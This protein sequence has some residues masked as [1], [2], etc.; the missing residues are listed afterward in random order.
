[1]SHDMETLKLGFHNPLVEPILNN[2]I[3]YHKKL[4]RSSQHHLDDQAFHRL[5]QFHFF[6]MIK[7]SDKKKVAQG[8]K[9]FIWLKQ[10]QLWF[11]ISGKSHSRNLRQLIMPHP[12]S[13]AVRNQ[14]IHAFCLHFGSCPVIDS[15]FLHSTQVMVLP[16]MWRVLLYQLTIKAAL[17]SH[18]Y[19]P[20]LS[21]QFFIHALS[22]V[23][24][25]C[26]ELTLNYLRA[27]ELAQQF[28]STDYFCRAL[29]FSS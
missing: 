15:L 24:L 29:R 2:I 23:I 25:S 22:E 1:M 4:I 3:I 14:Y 17:H 12:Q 7:Y 6:T 11:I 20:T 18:V 9:R 16:I 5:F 13:R 27:G 8:R 26:R 21:R 19:R 28:K 10:F